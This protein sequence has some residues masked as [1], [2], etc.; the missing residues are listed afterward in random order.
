MSNSEPQAVLEPNTRGWAHHKSQVAAQPSSQDAAIFKV[1]RSISLPF[2]ELY[3]HVVFFVGEPT[4]QFFD[5]FP[6]NIQDICN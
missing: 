2:A 4:A 3:T 1:N 6:T 5:L